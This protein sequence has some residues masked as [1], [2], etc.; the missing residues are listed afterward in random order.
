MRHALAVGLVQRVGNLDGVMQDLIERQWTFLQPL[1]QRLA[2]QVFHYEEIDSVLMAYV[3]ENANMR[4]V[5]AGNGLCFTL[6][7]LAQ[8]GSIGK[9]IREDFAS[10]NAIQ[11]RV[12]GA[13]DLAHPASANTGENFVR[14]QTFAG[15]DRHGLL[16]TY[17]RG[18]HVEPAPENWQSITLPGTYTPANSCSF[19]NSEKSDSRNSAHSLHSGHM[20]R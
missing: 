19:P 17:I 16:P 2:L 3:V 15:K 20:R 8:F 4:M 6:E 7:A 5:Q 13:V 12:A 18:V 10:D 1:R 11:T 9:V 14:A